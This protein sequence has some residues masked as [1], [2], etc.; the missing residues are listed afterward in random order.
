MIFSKKTIRTTSIP[1]IRKIHSGVWSYRPKTL[2]MAIFCQNRI[3]L[4]YTVWF[5]S[6]KTTR[7]TSIPTSTPSDGP[8]LRFKTI[9][10]I[11]ITKIN[12]K[13]HQRFERK[14]PKNS[15]NLYLMSPQAMYFWPKKG[16]NS[17]N[18]IFPGT[19]NCFFQK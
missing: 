11:Q 12:L 8:P 18:Q 2:K 9:I 4:A 17:Q 15:P 5:F 19:F 7:T 3:F 13:K 1:K 14:W 16:Q 6:K 10:L